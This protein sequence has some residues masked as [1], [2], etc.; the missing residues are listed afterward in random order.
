MQ[1]KIGKKN[2]KDVFPSQGHG[3][4]LLS[5]DKEAFNPLMAEKERARSS[6]KQTM[7]A[8]KRTFS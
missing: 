2:G 6:E 8:M 1:V 4:N 7:S 5:H 3:N